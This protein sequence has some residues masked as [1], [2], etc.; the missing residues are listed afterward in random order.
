MTTREPA[1]DIGISD[2]GYPDYPLRKLENG[3]IVPDVSLKEIQR[4][5]RQQV[6]NQ[7]AV[8]VEGD[9]LGYDYVV[10]PE[11]HF[12]V[13]GATSTNPLMTQATIAAQ[14][15]DVRLLQM[16]NILPWH[17]PVR[18]AEKTAM[19]DIVSDGRAEVGV[20]IG[21]GRVEAE[22]LGQHWAGSMDDPDSQQRTYEEKL[23]IL[24]QC[25]TDDLVTYDGEFHQVPPADTAWGSNQEYHYLE[26]G[27]TESESSD[28]MSFDGE[29]T[30]LASTPV[31]P[32]PVS[33]PHPQL[34]E[35]AM[36]TESL[37]RAAR[38]G[39]NCCCHCQGFSNVKERIDA[40]HDAAAEA[41]WPDHRP[42][43][44][45]EPFRRGWDARR[46]RGVAAI[47][48]VF[49]T[50]IA[51]E[52]TCER[53]E[54]GLA[55]D[56]C[57]SDESLPPENQDNIDLDVEEKLTEVDAPIIGDGEEI[58]DRI[59]TFAEICNYEDFALFVQMKIPGITHQAHLEQ[60]RWFASEVVPYLEDEFPSVQ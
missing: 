19:L 16:A 44:D 10:H 14:T 42:E 4:N 48:T 37:E 26:R 36:S 18:L 20:G 38:Q 13:L 5:Y 55:F 2:E 15:D 54:L 50:E 33:S 40:Y 45:G 29:N 3:F 60:L 27:A 47:L 6:R 12:Y 35:P 8:G 58:T 28:Y 43:W 23:D 51:D 1:V 41:G 7:V 32:Q 53:L 39:L 56:L 30:S 49:N 11:H 17:E 34:W 24:K 25:W 57:Q 52:E 31:H 46:R 9:R 22:I 21:Y 59:A